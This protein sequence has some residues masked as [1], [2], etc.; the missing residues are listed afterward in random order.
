MKSPPAAV[1]RRRGAR[2]D[3][4][5]S[6]PATADGAP[7]ATTF[8]LVRHAAH[9]RSA[10]VL[11]GRTPG[12]RARRGGGR[13]RERLARQL[14]RPSASPHLRSPR[15]RCLETAAPIARALRLGR[16]RRST[17]WTRSISAPGPATTSRLRAAIPPGARGTSAAP[18]RVRRRAKAW[19]TC[20]RAC[21]A[22]H[23]APARAL[24]TGAVALVSHAEVI[25]AARLRLS[26]P[27]ARRLV[28]ARIS[29]ASITQSLVDERGAQGPRRQRASAEGGVKLVVFG[30]T[31]QLLLGQ[32]PRHAVARAVSALL[33][34]RLARRRSSSATRPITRE[35][36]PARA[37]PAATSCSIAD[38]ADIAAWRAGEVARRG[39]R[40]GHLLLPGRASR[41]SALVL[42]APRPLRVFYDLD[43]PVTLGA[44]ARGRADAYV[45]PRRAPRL[46]ISC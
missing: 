13:R 19:S 40:H 8:F 10:R 29:P 5:P 36:R 21:V 6:S 42:D 30:L 26:R 46:T 16:S 39:R 44:P 1:H 31:D 20:K 2:A 24:R 9:E 27:L 43:T 11:A 28:A 32:R 35:P 4:E 25:R 14:A 17:T 15:E 23:R 22:A 3:A 33:A 37:S 18:C 38:W 41:P 12:V 45:G 7:S 34:A